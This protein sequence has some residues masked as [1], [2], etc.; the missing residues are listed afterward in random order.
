[1]GFYEEG[2]IVKRWHN[3]CTKDAVHF[4]ASFVSTSRCQVERAMLLPGKA[5]IMPQFALQKSEWILTITANSSSL[6]D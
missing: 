6:R 5:V 1:M 2:F 4:M 3:F